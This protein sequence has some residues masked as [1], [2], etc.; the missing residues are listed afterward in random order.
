MQVFNN[1]QEAIRFLVK[2]N[3]KEDVV[4]EGDRHVTFVIGGRT[5]EVDYV[6]IDGTLDEAAASAAAGE[7]GCEVNPSPI[8]A[9]ATAAIRLLDRV[10]PAAWGGDPVEEAARAAWLALYAT[11]PCD[12]GGLF[13]GPVQVGRWY[14]WDGDSA[15]AVPTWDVPSVDWAAW[16][17]AEEV[18]HVP[19]GDTVLVRRRYRPIDGD[20]VIQVL[21]GVATPFIYR[22]P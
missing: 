20:R 12:W 10:A 15:R 4:L 8:A 19:A 22:A 21:D 11:A 3:M 16:A 18:T 9:S 14:E 7:L 6:D 2:T 5:Y 13:A 17:A 1:T